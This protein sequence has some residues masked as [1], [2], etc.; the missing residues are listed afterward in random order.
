MMMMIIRIRIMTAF[1][2]D[3]MAML[4]PKIVGPYILMIIIKTEDNDYDYG[5]Y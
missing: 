2:S 5:Y 3:L 4:I 1:C